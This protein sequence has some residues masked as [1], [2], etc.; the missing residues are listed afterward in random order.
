MLLNARDC[1]TRLETRRTWAGCAAP[2]PRAPRPW[3][4]PGH[5]IRSFFHFQ[6]FFPLAIAPARKYDMIDKPRLKTTG[7]VDTAAAF[8]RDPAEPTA[9]SAYR[10]YDLHAQAENLDEALKSLKTG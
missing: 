8:G 6:R 3:R 1:P 5:L 7:S 10:L 2:W 4:H 9:R